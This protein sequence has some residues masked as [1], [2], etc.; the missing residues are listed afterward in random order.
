M[1]IAE[2]TE[3]S[4]CYEV[5]AQAQGTFRCQ[6]SF[7]RS[8][9]KKLRE[10]AD[11]CPMCR[12][13][14]KRPRARSQPRPELVVFVTTRDHRPDRHERDD[15]VASAR[16]PHRLTRSASARIR[17]VRVND[18]EHVN[19]RRMSVALA[20]INVMNDMSDDI[21]DVLLEDAA[22]ENTSSPETDATSTSSSSDDIQQ[23]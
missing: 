17:I 23:L 10:S 16:V 4:I 9:T 12:S 7:C 3:C 19:I 6:H 20:V 2:K 14:R 11:Q 18:T 5:R 22:E 21:Q 15:I 1:D 13:S 8:C